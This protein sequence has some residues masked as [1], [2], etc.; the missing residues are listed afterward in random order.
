MNVQL[1]PLDN[2]LPTRPI[3][4]SLGQSIK[5]NPNWLSGC[6]DH[7]DGG[8]GN[9]SVPNRPCT[10]HAWP[11]LLLTLLIHCWK[12]DFNKILLKNCNT[13]ALYESL[14]GPAMSSADNPQNTDRLGVYCRQSPD[15]TV[16]LSLSPW[17]PVWWRF[18]FNLDL[19]HMWRSGTVA[20]SRG[21]SGARVKSRSV[22]MSAWL[23]A[24]I[25]VIESMQSDYNITNKTT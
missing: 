22:G 18:S 14:D 11:E 16:R 7:Q 21:C 12:C 3:L 5:P 2:A 23:G 1:D 6:S 13:R 19:D 8:F 25:L 17:P 10:W 15:F 9:G 4:A 20:E 24:V